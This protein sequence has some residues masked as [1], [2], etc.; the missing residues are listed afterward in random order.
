MSL[1]AAALKCAADGQRVFPVRGKRPLTGSGFKD[2]TTDPETI[3]EWWAEHPDAG[4]APPTGDGLLVLD[5]DDETAVQTLEAEHGPLPPTVEVVTPRGRH[6]HFRGDGPCRVGLV[7]GIDVRGAGGYVVIPPTPGYE[8]RCAP[9]ERPLAV[10]SLPTPSTNG[11]APAVEG[12]IPECQRNSTLTS[13]A[14]TMRRRGFSG[15]A[16]TAALQEENRARC[17]PPLDESEV[18]KIA[19]SIAR[20]R[21]A[22]GEAFATLEEL[23]ALLGFADVGRRIDR[24][25]TFGR[26]STAIVHLELDGGTKLVLDPIGK[27]ATV[28]KLTAELALTVGATPKLKATDVIEVLRL[29]RQ[30]GQHHE[31]VELEDRAWELGADY[32]RAAVIAEATMA[33]QASRWEAF[34][35]LERSKRDDMILWDQATGMR[36]V[37]V[38]GFAS[39]VRVRVGVA[40][41]IL[42]EMLALGWRKRGAEGRIK[43][44][45]PGF[46]QAL[47][48]RF[49]EV[50]RGWE[51]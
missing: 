20:Y 24:V 15:A 21:P 6:L 47:I 29:I 12:D 4:I 9:D 1:L 7:P 32:L 40:E 11:T 49:F 48:F 46:R 39:F 26:G 34:V 17:Q 23:D 33:E 19:R 31:N 16:I 37:K 3:R 45:R 50:P 42:R 13:M 35:A 41:P 43:A 44:T 36:Y 27:F 2:A 25:K 10:W 51:E 22:S 38:G 18:A 14:G 5:I 8:W 30:L 28:G